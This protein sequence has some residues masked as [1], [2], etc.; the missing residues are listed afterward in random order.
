MRVLTI[1]NEY[2]TIPK[3]WLF[4]AGKRWVFQK[5]DPTA[6]NNSNLISRKTTSRMAGTRTQEV[7]LQVWNISRGFIRTSRGQQSRSFDETADKVIRRQEKKRHY[8]PRAQPL[9]AVLTESSFETVC[10]VKVGDIANNGRRADAM[11]TVSKQR[12]RLYWSISTQSCVK[13][14]FR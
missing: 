6:K 5:R 3:Q 4:A 8:F 2:V 9:S 12:R 7:W 13:C 11:W 14:S 10:H 1:S